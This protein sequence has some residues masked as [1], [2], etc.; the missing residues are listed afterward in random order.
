M[1]EKP[2][3]YFALGVT[4]VIS[5]GAVTNQLIPAVPAGVAL[6]DTGVIFPDG[7]EQ[8]TEARNPDP[9]CF[10]TSERFVDCGNG[11]VTDTVTG[12][13]YLEN[14]NCFGTQDWPT[15]NQ[16][17]AAL[18]DGSCGLTDGSRAGDWRAPTEEEWQGIARSAC[19]AP[20]IVG[21]DT[22]SSTSCYS[23][24]PWA[25][26]VQSSSYWSST[27]YTDFTGNALI[28]EMDEGNVSVLNKSFSRRVWPVRGG[29]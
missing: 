26:G 9:P 23:D 10:N 22:D 29:Q 3:L 25:S 19:S 1:T 8:T 4:T 12:L 17:A 5:I 18:A 28:M 11:T 20:K 16:T 14:V 15:A 24:D 6:S 7:S 2:W 21:N 13:I 27:T